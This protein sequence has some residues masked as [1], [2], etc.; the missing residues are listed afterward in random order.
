MEEQDKL[1]PSEGP[2]RNPVFGYKL[3]EFANHVRISYGNGDGRIRSR[4][5]N[6]G[7]TRFKERVAVGVRLQMEH[8]VRWWGYIMGGV[9]ASFNDLLQDKSPNACTAMNWGHGDSSIKNNG[10]AATNLQ[11]PN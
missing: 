7:N 5:V 4:N 9:L 1:S 8:M 11:G 10:L 3:F 2:H 6:T